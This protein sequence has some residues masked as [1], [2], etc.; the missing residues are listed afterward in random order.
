MARNYSFGK[1]TSYSREEAVSEL[2]YC[3]S[4]QAKRDTESRKYLKLLD[5]GLR[6]YDKIDEWTWL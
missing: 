5:T 3:H 1:N 6:R 4:V 2:P